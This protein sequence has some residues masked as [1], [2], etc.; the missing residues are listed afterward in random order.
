MF[1]EASHAEVGGGVKNILRRGERKG[2]GQ[3]ARGHSVC[4]SNRKKVREAG[5]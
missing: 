3:E 4:L 5:V 1:L 2:Q